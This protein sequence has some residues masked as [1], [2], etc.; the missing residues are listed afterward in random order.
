MYVCTYVAYNCEEAP[1]YVRTVEYAVC[2]N[3]DT[4]IRTYVYTFIATHMHTRLLM[5]LVLRISF[6]YSYT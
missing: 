3:Y 1:I 4:Y 2:N 5:C 6:T